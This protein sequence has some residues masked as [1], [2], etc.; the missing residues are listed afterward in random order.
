MPAPCLRPPGLAAFLVVWPTPAL[1]FQLR[2]W[3]RF[4]ARGPLCFGRR[5]SARH[6]P[7]VTPASDTQDHNQHG[8]AFDDPFGLTSHNHLHWI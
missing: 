8:R 6:F 1:R 7:A 5:F 4:Q 3:A 2:S